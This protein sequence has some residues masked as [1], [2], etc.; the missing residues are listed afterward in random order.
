MQNT[1]P[2][3]AQSQQPAPIFQALVIWGSLLASQGMIVLVSQTAMTRTPSAPDLTGARPPASA[4]GHIPS[5][6]FFIAAGVSLILA[7]V[8][9]NLLLKRQKVLT[10]KKVLPIWLVRWALLES[11]TLFGFLNAML[12]ANPQAIYPFAGA[13]LIGFVL[14]F[15]SERKLAALESSRVG[16]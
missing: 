5:S 13:S 4:V 8:I 2:N 1:R 6:F 10:V 14:S 3:Q 7:F 15:P 16:P 9:P 12:N 11:V